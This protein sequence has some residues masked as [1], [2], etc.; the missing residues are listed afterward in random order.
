M[1]IDSIW[2]GVIVVKLVEI[3]VISPPVGMNLFAVVGASDGQ[4][5]T[6][7]VFIGVLPFIVA[8]GVCLAFIFAFPAIATVLP[9]SMG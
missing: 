8:E 7:D 6:K 2:F 1:G 5:R 4:V 3:A 9:R